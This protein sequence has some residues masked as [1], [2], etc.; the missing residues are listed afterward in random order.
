MST[1]TISKMPA[2]QPNVFTAEMENAIAFIGDSRAR[3]SLALVEGF[4]PSLRKTH[5]FTE[6]L[7]RLG[8]VGWLGGGIVGLLHTAP[9][10]PGRIGDAKVERLIRMRIRDA[11]R[12]FSGAKRPPRLSVVHFQAERA[13]AITR[14]IDEAAQALAISR[15]L[16]PGRFTVEA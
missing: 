4:D 5:G 6:A 13:G 15:S 3:L 14:L 2:A 8:M 10:L 1:E 11:V 12:A 9:R 7:M 16:D